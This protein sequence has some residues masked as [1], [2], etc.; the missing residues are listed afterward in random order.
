MMD[1]GVT[2]MAY[3]MKQSMKGSKQT[4]KRKKVTKDT[5][6]YTP[7]EEG[8]LNHSSEEDENERRK[9]A[10]NLRSRS[11]KVKKSGIHNQ[12]EKEVGI[13]NGIQTKTGQSKTVVAPGSLSAYR[14]M[15]TQLRE[16][17]RRAKQSDL[18][19]RRQLRP[20]NMTSSQPVN[21]ASSD[22]HLGSSQAQSFSQPQRFGHDLQEDY[23][24]HMGSNERI[25]KQYDDEEDAFSEDLSTL[26]PEELG[27][28]QDV[29]LM[30]Q[31]Q[32]SEQ[33]A[34]PKSKRTRGP[35]MCK[36]VHEWTLEERKPIVLNEMG[37]PI[38]PDDKTVNTFT[39][40]LGT[41]AR[42]SSLAPLN[43]ISWHY[44]PDKE[45]IWSY[46]K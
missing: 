5:D 24:N 30:N 34:P 20:V 35:T 19:L 42:N 10:V 11:K 39:R 17:E 43:K 13:G 9:N 38:G 23:E 40:F 8:E 45:Q 25:L 32:E 4:K 33:I 28:M 29:P 21:M 31:E 6:E 18:L 14:Q 7:D 37:K 12:Q 15:Q 3:E 27:I 44:V 36:D 46:V 26:T 1:L 16:K 41:L 22:W 2:S